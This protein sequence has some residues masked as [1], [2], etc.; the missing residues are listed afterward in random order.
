MDAAFLTSLTHKKELS[1]NIKRWNTSEYEAAEAHAH[2]HMHLSPVDTVVLVQIIHTQ[3]LIRFSFSVLITISWNAN[4]FST[5]E[6]V[7][8]PD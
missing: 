4:L 2:V 6:K 5:L 1:L 3:L 7:G 8:N